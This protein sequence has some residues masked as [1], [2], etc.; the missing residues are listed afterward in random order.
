MLVHKWW[1]V[2][3]D[4]WWS[5]FRR[6][7]LMTSLPHQGGGGGARKRP[8]EVS[9][10]DKFE[11][12]VIREEQQTTQFPLLGWAALDVNRLSLRSYFPPR[13]SC[14]TAKKFPF[15]S[16]QERF[17]QISIPPKKSQSERWILSLYFPNYDRLKSFVETFF[18]PYYQVLSFKE[19]LCMSNMDFYIWY[20]DIDQAQLN[21]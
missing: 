13:M 2:R 3:R 15:K 7:C 19:Q 18:T 20:C 10:C 6:W 9:A 12:T 1:C 21:S 4:S 14:S 8:N 11:F 17:S 16:S 5:M